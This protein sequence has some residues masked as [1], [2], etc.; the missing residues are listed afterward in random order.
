MI[1][2]QVAMNVMTHPEVNRI[3]DYL[4]AK[5]VSILFGDSSVH[6]KRS[7]SISQ[8][9]SNYLPVY[10]ACLEHE[11]SAANSHQNV[12]LSLQVGLV[13]I[14]YFS[15]K[16]MSNFWILASMGILLCFTLGPLYEYRVNNVDYWEAEILLLTKG[17]QL[18]KK[19][20]KGGYGGGL[21]GNLWEIIRP[22]SHWYSVF[23]IPFVLLSW[24][25]ALAFFPPQLFRV[26]EYPS[27][28]W[29]LLGLISITGWYTMLILLRRKQRNISCR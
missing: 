8:R 17:T 1:K 29:F 3:D 2:L 11:A 21:F 23:F 10:Y 9:V 26:R 13:G 28:I 22:F 5:I 4:N 6:M 19:L 27:S 12:L 7:S 24:F 16:D 20:S 18:E 15:S 14:Q 25:S